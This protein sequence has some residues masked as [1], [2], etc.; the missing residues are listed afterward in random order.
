MKILQS[1]EITDMADI[2]FAKNSLRSIIKAVNSP[3]SSYLIF[4]LMELTTNII[5]HAHQGFIYILQSNN[6]LILS[7]LDYGSGIKDITWSMQNGTSA[8]KNSLGLGLYQMNRD[9]KYHVEIFSLKNV[10][11]HGSIVIVKPRNLDPNILSLQFLYPTESVCGDLFVKKGKYLLLADASGHG[12]KANTTA[13]FIKTY[14]FEHPFSCLDIDYFFKKLHDFLKS[15]QARGAA[16]SIF[17]LS[18]TS[19][20]VCGVGNISFWKY[21]SGSYQY[22]SQKEGVIGEYFSSTQ[23]R[24]FQFREKDILIAATDGIDVSKMNT[25]LTKTSNS[26][27]SIMIALAA[28]HFAAVKYDD[29]TIVIIKR[30]NNE[31]TV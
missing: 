21:E 22:N 30:R 29:K 15:K 17:E 9:D 27:S 25:L 31:L 5:K 12:K 23:A 8:K 28:M 20:Q 3:H 14:F 11:M 2:L 26:V 18:D 16:L 6:E 10:N 19:V 24:E 4:S 13:S 1:I 7:A